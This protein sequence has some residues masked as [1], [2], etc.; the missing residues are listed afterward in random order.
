[1][2]ITGRWLI[3]IINTNLES[4]FIMWIYKNEPLE[5][6][7]ENAYGYV[8]LITNNLTGRKYIGKKLFWFRKTKV[9]KG[10]KKRIKVES[11]WRSY[12]S[13]S[14]EVKKDVQ[15]IGQENFTREILHICTN[16]GSCNYLEAKEQMLREV[17]ETKLYYNSQIQCRVHRTHLKLN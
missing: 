1:M 17:L 9:V 5:E 10:K 3:T 8:Y 15:E 13:S 14:D 4:V 7:P 12:W 16:K 11:D 2:G 6:V